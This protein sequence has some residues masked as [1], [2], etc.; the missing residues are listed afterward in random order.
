MRESLERPGE[1]SIV[2]DT[3]DDPSI[4]FQLQGS[5]TLE[6]DD[7]DAVIST[8]ALGDERV[9]VP[10]SAMPPLLFLRFVAA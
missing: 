9:V 5:T 3:I 7:W 1:M 2:S 4:I 10:K 8:K 6:P